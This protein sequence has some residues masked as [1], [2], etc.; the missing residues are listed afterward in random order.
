[1]QD[2]MNEDNG[3]NVLQLLQ[4]LKVNYPGFQYRYARDSKKCLTAWMFMTAEMQ[5][6]A[7]RYGQVLFLDWMKSGVSD[8]DWPYQ[9]SVVLDEELSVHIVAHNVACTESNEACK[10]TLESMTLI[11][12]EL[13]QIT[14]VTFSDRLASE[15]TF[16]ECLR[17]LK[18]S[19]L[20][21]WHI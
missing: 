3:T 18:L 15:S 16:F 4:Q 19:A 14:Q 10:F 9:A 21:N 8:I 2:H 20:C 6:F 17:S 12:P 7:K 1:M 11:V 5:F 13:H